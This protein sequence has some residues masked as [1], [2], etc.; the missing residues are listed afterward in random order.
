MPISSDNFELEF[1]AVY[2]SEFGLESGNLSNTYQH[3]MG[4]DMRDI[5]P[6]ATL[7]LAR[8]LLL[9]PE[10]LYFNTSENDCR[11]QKQLSLKRARYFLCMR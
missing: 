1:T 3:Q 7:Q 11:L 10:G 5:R 6:S 9:E 2:V 8:E 4:W